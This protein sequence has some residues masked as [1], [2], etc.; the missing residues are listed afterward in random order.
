MTS[1]SRSFAAHAAI[2]ALLAAPTLGAQQPAAFDAPRA[3]TVPSFAVAPL[4]AQPTMPADSARPAG[5]APL[6]GASAAVR[7][8]A[9]SQQAA[10]ALAAPA[11][12]LRQSQVLMV[13]GAAAVVV[14]LVAGGDAE[15]PLVVGG[16]I[17]GLYGLYQYLR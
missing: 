12:S 3:S 16:A 14:G 13:V 9:R 17:I 10:P 2:V 6:A 7:A 4:P 11:G 5:G 8:P 15:A 1:R